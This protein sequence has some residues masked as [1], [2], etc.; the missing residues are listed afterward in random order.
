[1]GTVSG[2]SIRNTIFSYIGIGLAAMNNVVLVPRAFAIHPEEEWGLAQYLMGLIIVMTPIASLG[3]PNALIRYMPYYR[4]GKKAEFAYLALL[5]S[6]ISLSLAILGLFVYI[7]GFGTG[8]ENVLVKDYIF[9]LIP[10]LIGSALFEIGS[11]YSRSMFKSILPVFLKETFVRICNSVLL[12]LYWQELIGFEAFIF[13]FSSVYLL[14]ALI[15]LLYLRWSRILRFHKLS[16]TFN[17]KTIIDIAKFGLIVFL[18][19]ESSSLIQRMDIILIEHFLDLK[20]V[21]YYSVPF[22][23]GTLISTPG[24]SIAMISQSM[25]A[26]YWK[27]SRM[28][29]ILEIYRQTSITQLVLGSIIF[30]GVWLNMDVLLWVL[31]IKFGTAEA[32]LVFLFIALGKLFDTA[33]G[34]NGQILISSPFYRFDLYFQLMLVI[35]TILLDLTLIPLLGIVGAAIAAA[36]AAFL[37][38]LLKMIFLYYRIGQH[39]FSFRTMRALLLSAAIYMLVINLPMPDLLIW[40]FI[41]RTALICTGFAVGIFFLDISPE[42]RELIRKHVKI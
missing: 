31:G 30:L 25:I 40:R 29:K 11:G 17:R 35:L 9:L 37:H 18:S 10:M 39:P 33:T 27:T 34:A 28:D 13:G 22:Y 7:F 5:A 26:E 36:G 6:V 14:K 41:V 32:R 15:L 2:Q 42:I 8:S 1:M 3:I 4:E 20:Q 16:A 24:R 21:A 19:G 12:L 23:I 38:N